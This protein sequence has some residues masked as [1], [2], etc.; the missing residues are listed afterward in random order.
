MSVR[1][2]SPAKSASPDQDR[3][4]S[5]VEKLP[6]GIVILDDGGNICFCNPA[7][8]ELFGRN[9]RQLVGT[10]F[11]FPAVDG[12]AGEIE[13]IRPGGASVMAELRLVETEWDG[14]H[15]RLVSI[16]NVTDRKRAAERSAQLERE[17]I[18]RAEAEAASQAKSD[19][20][21]TMSH[22]LRTPLN[23]VLG[24]AELLDLGISGTLS[25]EQRKQIHRIRDSARHLLGLV[26]EVLDLAKVE[27][28]RLTVQNDAVRAVASV[29]AALLVVQPIAEARRIVLSSR[30]DDSGI[31]Y[32][33]DE[34]RVTQ[35]V[36]NLLSNAVKF[37]LPGGKIDVSCT[38]VSRPRW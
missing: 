18:A 22:E 36:I 11:G 27:A 20:L 14:E 6:D 30:C 25:Q 26:N 29:E 21:A 35:I 16:R 9:L 1:T 33:G 23:A 34:E 3:L 13:I 2:H 4:Q 38:L 17:R 8:E 32:E 24:Y 37:T 31:V 28:G 5:I 19:F 12:D 15:V 7:A 10:E